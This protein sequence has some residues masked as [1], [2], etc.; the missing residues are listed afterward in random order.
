MYVC[1]REFGAEAFQGHLV[2]GGSLIHIPVGINVTMR[3]AREIR[4]IVRVLNC[5]VVEVLGERVVA[6]G[7]RQVK[8]VEAHRL[9]RNLVVRVANSVVDLD[10][11]AAG[12]RARGLELDSRHLHARRRDGQRRRG[13]ACVPRVRPGVIPVESSD[14]SVPGASRVRIEQEVDRVEVR[15]LIQSLVLHL[16]RRHTDRAI[17]DVLLHIAIA[18]EQTLDSCHSTLVGEI[19]DAENVSRVA[20]TSSGRIRRV[21]I[22]CAQLHVG[23]GAGVVATSL[24]RVL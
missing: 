15:T 22:A 7:P 3:V 19:G 16:V 14:R 4:R 10:D 20:A 24:R 23:A 17:I 1:F 11:P 5:R 18:G 21:V 13:R 6:V 8:R 9:S 12:L 2:V